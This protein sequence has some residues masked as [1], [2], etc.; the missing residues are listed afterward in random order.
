MDITVFEKIAKYLAV[1]L[2]LVGF[3]LMLAYVIHWQ[4]IKSGLL[5]KVD[6]QDSGLIIRLFLRYG[7][8]L[9]LV[10]VLAMFLLQF[11][12]IGLSAWNSYMKKD[13]LQLVP[14]QEQLSAKDQQLKALTEAFAALPKT[15]APAASIN[16]AFEEAKKG[17]TAKAQD[18]F[19][20]VLKTKEAEGQK[21]NNKEAAA[22]ARH[23]GALAY[24][25]NTKEALA[26]YQKAVQLDPNDEDGWNMLGLLLDRT[27]DL[28]QAEAAYRKVLALGTTKQDRAWQAKAICNLGNVAYT[29]GKLDKAEEMYRK[30]LEIE[31]ALGSKEGM[32][33]DYANLGYVYD[34]RGELDKAEEMYRKALTL[35]QALDSKEGMAQQYGNMGNV[36]EI[37]GELDKAEEMYRKRLEI[38]Q[39]LGSKEGMALNYGNLGSVYQTRGEL[40]KAEEMY[41]KSLEISEALGLKEIT[42]I[43]YGNLGLVYQARGELDKAEELWKKSLNLYQTMQAICHPCAKKV[44]RNLDNLTQHRASQPAPPAASPRR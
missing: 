16:A 40:D 26:A 34:T 41:R 22:I 11:S 28:A 13:K 35:N 21:T 23:L 15:G 20:E 38:E 2:V 36:Y 4:L 37:R 1:P 27:G 6:K 33:Q 12:G 8:W 10:L 3:A 19:A 30:S 31:Q 25:D 17:K 44:Q 32:A 39:A 7:F 43:L 24:Q 14:L 5:S 18:I 42:G 9:G 29:R